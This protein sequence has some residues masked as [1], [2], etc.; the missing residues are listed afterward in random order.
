M[1]SKWGHSIWIGE[2]SNLLAWIY[3]GNGR[4]HGH[5]SSD[6]IVLI[7]LQ[8]HISPRKTS[9]SNHETQVE[10]TVLHW[11]PIALSRRSR[12]TLGCESRGHPLVVAQSWGFSD[13]WY[14]SIIVLVLVGGGIK[15]KHLVSHLPPSFPNGKAV[16]PDL[17]V[18]SEWELSKNTRGSS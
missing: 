11:R 7:L 6:D 1:V 4:G 15:S 18:L 10:T 16:R 17:N 8:W 14:A 5:N 9:A 2:E 13:H 12:T 3:Y